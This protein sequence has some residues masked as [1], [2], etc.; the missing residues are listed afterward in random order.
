M[1]KTS[2]SNLSHSSPKRTRLG[3]SDPESTQRDVINRH[4]GGLQV[5]GR[6]AL[7][8]RNR[9]GFGA[10]QLGDEGGRDVGMS[11]DGE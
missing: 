11:R 1:K 3:Y 4:F 5:S 9:I 2:G 10:A 8:R 6:G 7:C